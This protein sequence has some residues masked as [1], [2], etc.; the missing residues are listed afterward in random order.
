MGGNA[1]SGVL[2]GDFILLRDLVS[3]GVFKCAVIVSDNIPGIGG[4]IRP[5]EFR[6]QSAVDCYVGLQLVCGFIVIV[7]VLAYRRRWEAE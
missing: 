3:Q 6:I 4:L 7:A 1:V 5:E 2:Y